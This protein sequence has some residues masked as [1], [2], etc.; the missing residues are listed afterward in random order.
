MRIV[1]F[2][3]GAGPEFGV[4]TDDGVCATGYTDLTQIM[5]AGSSARW[6]DSLHQS[7]LPADVQLLAPQCAPGKMLF[8]GVNYRS[9]LQE[10]PA[11]TLPSEPLWFAKLPSAL[12]GPGETI[13]PP[14]ADTLLDYEVELAV[15]IGRRA[16]KIDRSVALDYVFGYTLINDVSARD[17]QFDRGQLTLGKGSDTFCPLGPVIVTA[18]SMGPLSDEVL[19]TTVNGETRQ[20]AQAG[21]MLFAIPDLL[22]HLTSFITL[23]PGDVVTTGTPAGVGCFMNPPGYL[24][25]G[26]V[27]TVSS[28]S[29]GDLTNPVGKPRP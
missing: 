14:T 13:H 5:R 25:P 27:V 3:N 6:L 26:D 19:T 8:C 17:L 15:I 9:H 23:E 16:S 22:E 10:N 24:N 2:D 4:A 7:L 1:R 11:A 28:T 18:D 21:E 12:I 29:I 20:R